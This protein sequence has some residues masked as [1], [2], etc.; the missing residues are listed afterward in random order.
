MVRPGTRRKPVALRGPSCVRNH[1]TR[2]LEM[3]SSR[4]VMCVVGAV[5]TLAGTTAWAQEAMPETTPTVTDTSLGDTSRM[6]L[7]IVLSPMPV[8]TF[9][10]KVAGTEISD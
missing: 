4:V 1:A 3:I 5:G 7:G 10:T 8:G 9:K 6:R 2:R